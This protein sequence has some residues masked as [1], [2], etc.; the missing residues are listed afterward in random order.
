MPYQVV[1]VR[2]LEELAGRVAH[3]GVVAACAVKS[4]AAVESVIALLD[5]GPEP[6]LILVPASVEDPRNLG[7]I[8]RSAVAF[9]V[10]A[11][12]LE[13]GNTAP[14]SETVAKTSAGMLEHLPICRPRSL[15]AVLDELKQRGLRVVG[16]EAGATTPPGQV[17]FRQSTVIILGGEHRGLPAYLRKRCDELVGIPIA[18]KAESL[19]VSVAAGVLLYECQRQRLGVPAV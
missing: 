17:D 1:P 16:A 6:P 10:D 15:E 9:G 19:N 11:I 18:A 8:I 4:Y 3:Q 12:L 5:Q 2:R 13:R 7:S 14:L